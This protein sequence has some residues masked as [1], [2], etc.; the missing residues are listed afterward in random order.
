[1]RK[2]FFIICFS[3]ISAFKLF[4]Q[5]VKFDSLVQKGIHEIYGMKFDEADRTF[6]NLMADYPN[7]P[8]GRFF[9]AMIDWQRILVDLD[10]EEYDDIF[11]AK[12]ED[13]IFQCD[14]ILD[15]DE[16]NF[17]AWFFKGGSIGFRGRLRAIRES[18]LKA[19]DDGRTAMPI[20]NQAYQIDSSNADIALG[21]GIYNYYAAVVPDKYPFVKPVMIFFPKGD[22]VKGLEQLKR[23]AEGGKYAKYESRYFLLT[24]NYQFENNYYEAERWAKILLNDFP[25]N[26][27]FQR[28]LGR[29]NVKLGRLDIA[30][31]IFGD[32]YLKCQSGYEG[33]NKTA[34]REA[35]YYTGLY[36]KNMQSDLDSAAI[37]FKKCEEISRAIDK[38]KES[39][40]LVNSVLYLGMIADKKNSREEALKYY[41]E[42][43]DMEDFGSAHKNAEKYKETPFK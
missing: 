39:G 37:W 32:I 20:V 22:R 9:L 23:V 29:I 40:F 36:Y 11:F 34:E 18:W 43:L 8:A 14:Q 3:A 27:V 6:K 21:F 30:K 19:A 4:P 10:N 25:D 12:L 38:K 24:L 42:V 26:P 41:E 35:V 13:V 5:G 15:K 33:Y 7:H 28:Y 1:M 16:N 17:D 31:N 2:L